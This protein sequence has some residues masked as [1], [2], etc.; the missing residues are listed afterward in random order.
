M[1]VNFRTFDG[2]HGPTLAFTLYLRPCAWR[3]RRYITVC[4]GRGGMLSSRLSSLRF[5]PPYSLVQTRAAWFGQCERAEERVIAALANPPLAFGFGSI[6]NS[7]IS[8]LSPLL[9]VRTRA[10]SHSVHRPDKT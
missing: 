1:V 5:I 10:L 2:S 4:A 6:P 9:S 3:Y 7:A 8:K